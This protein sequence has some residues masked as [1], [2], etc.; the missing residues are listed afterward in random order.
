MS[1]QKRNTDRVNVYLDGSFAFGLT[2]IRAA[3]LRVGQVLRDDDI[4]R[5]REQ[6]DVDRSYE[7][8]LNFLSYRPR[9]EDEVRRN[10]RKKNVEDEVIEDVIERLA[11]AGLVNDEEFARYWVDNRQE[12]RP[13]GVRALRYELRQ[14]GV[15]DAI[16]TQALESVDEEAAVRRVAKA[17]A[18]RFGHLDASGFRRKFG[19]FLARRGF[20]YAIIVPLIQEMLASGSGSPPSQIDGERSEYG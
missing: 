7:R 10:L 14:K 17:G 12:F 19:A 11:H 20:S 6:D 15:P 9:S 18:R 16:V 3:S 4:A 5:L 2:A 1:F 8:A 13:R